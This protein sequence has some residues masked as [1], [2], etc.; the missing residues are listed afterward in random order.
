MNPI[1]KSLLDAGPILRALTRSR[2]GPVLIALQCAITLAILTNAIFIIQDRLK[3]MA[4]PSGVDVENV[5]TIRTVPIHTPVNFKAD[6]ERDLDAIRAL[7]GVAEAS[8]ISS[9][10]LSGGGSSTGLRTSLDQKPGG[11]VNFG[12]YESDTHTL[13]TLGLKLIAGRNFKPEEISSHANNSERGNGSI[14]ASEA[15]L[16]EIFPKLGRVEE[17]LGKPLYSDDGKFVTVVGVVERL[18]TPWLNW[19]KLENAVLL[20]QYTLDPVFIKYIV[21]AAPGE[22]DRVMAEVEKRLSALDPQRVIKEPKTQAEIEAKAYASYRAMAVILVFVIALI[23]AITALG[24]V[25]LASFNVNARKKQIGTRRALGATKGDI[26]RYFLVESWL[27]TTVGALVGAGLSFALSWWMVNTFDLP[28]LD[29]RYIP[30][31][32][33]FLWLLGQLA[34]LLPARRASQ[35]TPALATRSV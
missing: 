13:D 35:L 1:Q 15:Y 5:F 30:V 14:I 11:E 19:G 10:P 32:V 33:V 4:R 23:V 6:I 26:V 2:A 3:K 17:A 34:V 29:W 22:R 12:Y 24:I 18:Q 27:I 25:G 31:G 28:R 7:P 21:R 16:R 8:I 20:S 9:L